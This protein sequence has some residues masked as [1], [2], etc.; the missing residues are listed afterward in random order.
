MSTATEPT[1][2]CSYCSSETDMK[3]EDLDYTWQQWQCPHCAS[4]VDFKKGEFVSLQ[5]A[6]L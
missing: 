3:D 1:L 4:W 6:Q 5:R 2:L